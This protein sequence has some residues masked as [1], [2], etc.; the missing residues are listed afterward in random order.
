MQP[1]RFFMVIGS[2]WS[3]ATP[4]HHPNAWVRLA[5]SGNDCTGC[6]F[7]SSVVCGHPRRGTRVV[8]LRAVGY[9]L[10]WP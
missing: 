1:V 6:A 4:L 8:V 7:A 3:R 10:G 5:V 9:W 2:S